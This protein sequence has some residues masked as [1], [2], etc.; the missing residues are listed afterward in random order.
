MNYQL[1]KINYMQPVIKKRMQMTWKQSGIS[2]FLIIILLI[3]QIRLSIAEEPTSALTNYI[4][5][6][7]K[8]DSLTNGFEDWRGAYL[9][10][11]WQQDNNNLWDWETLYY[12]QYGESGNYIVGGLTHIF[13]SD[14]YGSIHAGYSGNGFF[15]PDYR[16]D[17]Y[18]HRKVL[19]EQNLVLNA[20]AGYIVQKDEHEDRYIHLG[21]TYYFPDFWSIEGG[22]RFNESSPGSVSSNRY[23]FALS[24]AKDKVRHIA[25]T[26]DWGDESYLAIG[27]TTSLVDFSSTL[28]TFQWREWIN[29]DFGIH[30]IGEYYNSDVFNRTGI[31]IGIFKEF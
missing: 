15:F 12:E 8:H 25:F 28:L 5:G 11:A 24:H 1:M 17:A 13:N 2:L 14:W 22:V 9:Q 23:I 6:G 20:G 30:L 21:A 4:E 29:D 31:S 19:P 3:W 10:G 18:I 16:V 27:P 26:I 7:I